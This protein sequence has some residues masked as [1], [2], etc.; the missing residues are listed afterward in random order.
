VDV[1]A[2]AE[3]YELIDQAAADGMA[4]LVASSEL[5]ELQLICHRIAVLRYGRVTAVLEGA[6]ATKERIMT[7]AAGT[8]EADIPLETTSSPA[9]NGA[10]T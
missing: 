2:K 9:P 7:A 10:G 4:V 8:A 3:I 5:E 6:D 1:G